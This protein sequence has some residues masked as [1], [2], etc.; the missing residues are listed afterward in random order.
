M[1]LKESTRVVLQSRLVGDLEKEHA[2]DI[3]HLL[4]CEGFRFG[5]RDCMHQKQQKH[6]TQHSEFKRQNSGAKMTSGIELRAKSV[7]QER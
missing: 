2:T 3:M 1:V 6:H 7:L 5:I 4:D